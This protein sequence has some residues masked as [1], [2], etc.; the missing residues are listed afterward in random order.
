ML[1]SSTAAC[2][3]V[4]SNLFNWEA[5]VFL[6]TY[7]KVVHSRGQMAV[8]WP[9]QFFVSVLQA[10]NPRAPY[11]P[12]ALATRTNRVKSQSLQAVK[13]ERVS[14]RRKERQHATLSQL[15][16]S[17]CL[18]SLE[19]ASHCHTDSR[20]VFLA[21]RESHQEVRQQH[22]GWGEARGDRGAGHVI[23]P[24]QSPG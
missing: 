18:V 5:L 21:H 7:R 11:G 1:F 6:E 2:K 9:I 15:T 10:F 22:R 19:A 24:V 4:R 17:S 16:S 13:K 23:V 8:S 20:N 14:I 3:C 12:K